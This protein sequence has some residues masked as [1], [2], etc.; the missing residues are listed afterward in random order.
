M[1]REWGITREEQDALAL[2]SHRTRPRPM[3]RAFMTT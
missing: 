2:K 1:A 3:T